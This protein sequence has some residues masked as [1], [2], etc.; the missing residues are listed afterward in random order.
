[1]AW[2]KPCPDENRS[3]SPILLGPN[4]LKKKLYAKD[5]CNNLPRTIASG[6]S[7]N[8]LRRFRQR[9][10]INH[11]RVAI[12]TRCKTDGIAPALLSDRGDVDGRSATPAD[13]VLSFL[14]VAVSA[15]DETRIERRAVA[16]RLLDH[17]EPDGLATHVDRKQVQISILDVRH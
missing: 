11:N 17:H 10:N 8:L 9:R 5:F 2:L 4:L 16:T 3:H 13:D 12:H 6:L 7:R 15:A 1:M 14:A